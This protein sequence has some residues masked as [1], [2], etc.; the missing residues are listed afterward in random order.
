MPVI[1]TLPMAVASPCSREIHGRPILVRIRNF[2]PELSSKFSGSVSLGNSPKVRCSCNRCGVPPWLQYEAN[3]ISSRSVLGDPSARVYH[4]YIQRDG[5]AG[6]PCF[7]FTE[8]GCGCKHLRA[9]RLIIAERVHL[10]DMGPPLLT[11]PE[12]AALDDE[13]IEQEL[14]MEELLDLEGLDVL[15]AIG[16]RP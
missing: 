3:C 15:T 7:D 11:Q 13:E 16:K 8:N 12:A 10:L 9:L 4:L 14:D 2:E 1:R 6:C 5:Y